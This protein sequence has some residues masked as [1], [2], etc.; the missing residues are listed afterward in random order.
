MMVGTAI[1]AAW[2]FTDLDAL[3]IIG[4][5]FIYGGIGL[6]AAGIASL[7]VF[8]SRARKHGI[9]HRRPTT[10]ALVVLVLN[11]PLCVAYVSIAFTMETAHLVTVANRSITPIEALIVTDP[12]GQQFQIETIGPGEVRHACFDLS[13]EGAVQFTFNV[14]GETRAGTLIGYLAA[15][16]GSSATLVL[17][18]DLTARA[19]EEFRRISVAD[20]L[21]HCALGRP[22]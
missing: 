11:F 13:G 22:T 12:T 17:S 5:F 16:I 2:L 9:A 8:V 7:L 19:N 20:F 1:F 10:V 6:F 3:E 14:D 4:L 15:P 18:E 21:R